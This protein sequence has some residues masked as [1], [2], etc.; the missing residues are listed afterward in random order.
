MPVHYQPLIRAS[1]GR[2]ARFEALLRLTRRNG[3]PIPPAEFLPVAAAAGMIRAIGLRTLRAA[4]QTARSWPGEI[5]VAVNLSAQ[6]L[7]RE[8]PV[9]DV[10]SLFEELEFPGRRLELALS[11]AQLPEQ[12]KA[13]IPGQIAGLRALGVSI[14]IDDFGSGCSSLCCLWKYPFDRLKIDGVLLEAHAFRRPDLRN[15]IAA[16]A[17]LGRRLGMRVTVEG[18]E[19]AEQLRALRNI[20]CELYQGFLFDRPMPASETQSA[21]WRAARSAAVS[22]SAS[23]VTRRTRNPRSR[24]SVSARAWRVDQRTPCSARAGSRAPCRSPMHQ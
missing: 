18:V 24:A 16:L 2:V 23:S 3:A 20:D 15:V 8:T 17:M 5:F 14:A 21:G 1:D 19:T 22:M 6:Q 12:D 9:E 11:E 13:R 4:L 10:G 7:L